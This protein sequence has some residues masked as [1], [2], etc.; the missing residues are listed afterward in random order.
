MIIFALLVQRHAQ[1]ITAFRHLQNGILI[2][3]E[4]FINGDR[5]LVILLF[6]RGCC[7]LIDSFPGFIGLFPVPEN[8]KGL[9][10]VT[11]FRGQEACPRDLVL[12]VLISSAE[13]E[14]FHRV[15]ITLV[16]PQ[17]NTVLVMAFI[18]LLRVLQFL[19]DLQGFRVVMVRHVGVS[20]VREALKCQR[21]GIPVITQDQI[22]L[23]GFVI[24]SVRPEFP[25]RRV[26]VL[27]C[28]LLGLQRFVQVPVVLPGACQ[29]AL[30]E[31]YVALHPVNIFLAVLVSFQA[32]KQ[33]FRFFK[34]SAVH[35]SGCFPVAA[36]QHHFG[37]VLIIVQAGENS[38]R[39]IKPFLFQQIGGFLVTALNRLLVRVLIGAQ[40]QILFFRLVIPPCF[41]RFLRSRKQVPVIQAMRLVRRIQI[42]VF[43]PGACQIAAVIQFV[44]RCLGSQETAVL[45]IGNRIKNGNR[46]LVLSALRQFHRLPVLFPGKIVRAVTV[47]PQFSENGL[48]LRGF[49]FRQQGLRFPV[50]AFADLRQAV[51]VVAQRSVYRFRFFVLFLRQQLPRLQVAAV[52]HLHHAVHIIAKGLISQGSLFIL[53]LL[54]QG[55]RLAVLV[56]QLRRVGLVLRSQR[57]VDFKRAFPVPCLIQGVRFCFARHIRAVQ[58]TAQQAE[59]F[60]CLVKFFLFRKA[61]GVI[62]GS[63]HAGVGPGVAVPEFRKLL[64]SLRRGNPVLHRLCAGI[65]LRLQL[66]GLIIG[67]HVPAVPVIPQFFQGRD[68]RVIIALFTRVARAAIGGQRP[69]IIVFLKPLRLLRRLSV[70]SLGQHR[71]NDQPDLL[72]VL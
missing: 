23:S 38:F 54:F 28:S 63:L 69:G 16:F 14:L 36:F 48:R 59:G 15:G 17:V 68:G 25:S 62:I 10:Q 8:G 37:A 57:A 22:L 31:K 71:F 12:A 58:V 49:S 61:Y 6:N 30:A 42:P 1:E 32:F 44:R 43:R 24:L 65:G 51:L 5:Q 56:H 46:F 50:P 29:V 55:A 47:I 18:D 33:G 60:L 45:V 64:V 67:G 19:I 40:R 41:P 39:L 52:R 72:L 9:R 66:P 7:G 34:P 70:F 2:A 13:G 4:P 35:Q 53:P 21:G 11:V 26:K 3:A 27:V 20:L